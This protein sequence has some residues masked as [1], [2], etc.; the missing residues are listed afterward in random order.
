MQ[1]KTNCT[2]LLDKLSV[3][4]KALPGRMSMPA[5]DGIY[6]KKDN[7]NLVLCSNDL[8]IAIKAVLPLEQTIGLETEENEHTVL[9]RK[10]IQVVKQLPD[11]QVEIAIED[12]RAEIRSGQSKFT[13]MCANGDDFPEMVDSES[14]MTNPCI[15][16]KGAALKELIKKTT[17]CVSKD[18]GKAA[19]EGVLILHDGENKRTVCVSSDTY[20]L[21][22]YEKLQIDSTES[23][24][25]LVPG[26]LLAEVGRIVNDDDEITVYISDKEIIIV[27]G[28]YVISLRLLI[29]R[30]PDMAKVIPEQ[31]KTHVKVN[32]QDFMDMVNR[33]ELLASGYNRMFGVSIAN[34]CL[35]AN[36]SSEMGK[37]DEEAPAEVSG[38]DLGQV[39]LNA[40]YM[41]DGL[42]AFDGDD[43]TIEF[44][45]A[46]G[47]VVMKNEGFKYL[48]LPIKK[49]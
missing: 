47:P 16:L 21:A 12:N 5:I 10:F 29:E 19:F 32:R 3:V 8:E 18:V 31:A 6:L 11:A 35:K 38:D 1:I 40:K 4:E 15:E 28:D 7:D 41:L 37:M 22:W 45:G 30:Y 24:R 48:V 14:Y 25:V 44:N 34:G 46:V 33:A 20:R 36:A 49:D 27:V 23:F 42:K 17:F 26:R 43:L 13:L 39:L 2:N 9:P